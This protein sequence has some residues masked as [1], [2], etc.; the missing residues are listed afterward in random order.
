MEFLKPKLKISEF[1]FTFHHRFRIHQNI[2]T[3]NG[4]ICLQARLKLN[5]L[6]RNSFDAKDDD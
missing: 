6:L 5:L 2:F 3:S 1:Y 4:V